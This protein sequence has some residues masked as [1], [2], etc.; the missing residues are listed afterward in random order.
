MAA[1]T[2]NR[3][4]RELA[5][6]RGQVAKFDI[7]DAEIV[8]AGGMLA[9]DSAGEVHAASDTLGLRVLGRVPAKV[10]NSAD[11]E[12]SEV[13]R[14]IFRYANSTSHALSRN[15][16]GQPCY[17]EDDQTVAGSSTNLVPAGLVHDV[18]SDG[19]WVDQSLAA[20]QTAIAAARKKVVA[21][22]DTTATLTAA[23]AFQGNVVI[24]AENDG[25]TTLTLPAAAA[26]YRL[27]IQRINAGDGYD[28]VV[29]AASGDKVRGSTAG[30]TI[31]ND[32]DAVSDVLTLETI[33]AT[34][35]VDATPLAK[36]RAEWAP[37]T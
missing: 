27:G 13:Q 6:G 18:D 11:G 7:Y 19:V 30:G 10:D 34:D 3:D 33:D 16:I 20:C 35:W 1:L 9:V 21:V 37:S 2:D 8:Y 22:T 25:A 17:V 36:D 4:T 24:T 26:G 14:G 5:S 12:K 32:T 28:V 29:T 15:N 31:T 23:Q